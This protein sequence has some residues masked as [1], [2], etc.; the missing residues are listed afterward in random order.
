MKSIIRLKFV[1]TYL[2]VLLSYM[3]VVKNME[4][5]NSVFAI[6]IVQCGT[7]SGNA[8]FRCDESVRFRSPT[9]AMHYSEGASFT[10][11]PLA[12]ISNLIFNKYRQSSCACK[13][14]LMLITEQYCKTY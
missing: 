5:Y 9:A 10:M 2:M 4:R 11:P 6:V 7:T 3:Q 14:W 12:N 1:D 13:S 8:T